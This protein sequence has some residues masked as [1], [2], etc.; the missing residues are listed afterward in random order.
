MQNKPIGG[1]NMTIYDFKAKDIDGHEVSLSEYK[2]KVLLVVNTASKCGFTPQYEE[3]Q[4]LYQEYRDQG[5]EILA[6]P[7]NQFKAQEPGTNRETKNFCT[8]NYGVT[9]PLFEKTDVNGDHAHP[10]FNYLKECVP[11]EGMDLKHPTNKVISTILK[12]SYPEFNSGNAIRWNFTK[13]L[14]N[15]NGKVIK[16]FESSVEP[17]DL[18]QHIEPLL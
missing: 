17:R 18:A 13:F 8:Q 4:K 14:V 5:L 11:Y 6:F 12:D 7:S 2:N 16:R 3:L 9:F 1:N 15:K 10:V